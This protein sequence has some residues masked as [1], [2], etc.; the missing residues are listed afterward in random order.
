MKKKPSISTEKREKLR[1]EL[2]IARISME[3]V[4]EAAEVSSRSVM[5][6]FAGTH[7]NPRIHQ[8]AI[9]LMQQKANKEME[10]VSQRQ[11]TIA[12]LI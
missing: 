10:R 7:Y 4:A 1:E 6:F 9:R 2:R 11:Q 12:Q 5:Y 8:A 3:K